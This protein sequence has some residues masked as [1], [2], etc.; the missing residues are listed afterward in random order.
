MCGCWPVTGVSLR[1]KWITA[2]SDR[3]NAARRGDKVKTV[4]QV[5]FWLGIICIPLTWLMWYLGP[6]I[7]I[8]RQVLADIADPAL[9]T[10]LQEAHAER[11]GLFVAVWPATLLI[12]SYILER[13]A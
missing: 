12:L 3:G 10:A 6:E 7:E 13:K 4:S 2:L 5:L 11:L 1:I 8:G 9:K